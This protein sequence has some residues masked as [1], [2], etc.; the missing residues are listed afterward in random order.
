MELIMIL[1]NEY[2]KA[3]NRESN[4]NPFS[5]GILKGYPW[6]KIRVKRRAPA[7]FGLVFL[8]KLG[9]VKIF[10]KTKK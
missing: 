7:Y 1:S 9:S 8:V 2:S 6:V 3:L 10:C 5:V 4:R